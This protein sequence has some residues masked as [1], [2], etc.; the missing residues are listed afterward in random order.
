[1]K[2]AT[3][4]ILALTLLICLTACAKE[5]SGSAS[6]GPALKEE[7]GVLTCL[8]TTSSP[9]E[10]CAVRVSVDKTAGT[11]TFTKATK[12]GQDTKEYYRFTPSEHML[13]QFYYVSM[14][15]TGFY[16]YYDTDLGEMVRIEDKDHNDSTA[17]AKENGRF[18]GPAAQI[19]K[20]AATLEEFAD[21]EILPLLIFLLDVRIIKVTTV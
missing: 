10:D 16:Y 15:G 8:D 13:E 7:N 12:D 21:K 17:S 19:K 11:V 18:D 20:D 14:M 9:F 5:T 4:I 1:M 2:K 3:A 6:G